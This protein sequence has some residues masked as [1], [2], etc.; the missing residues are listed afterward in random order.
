MK[1]RPRTPLQTLLCKTPNYTFLK[2]FGCACFPMLRTHNSNKLQYWSIVYI[3]GLLLMSQ[4]IKSLT[5]MLTLS[6]V[7]VPICSTKKVSIKS[8]LPAQM[9]PG[10]IP[11]TC[12]LVFDVQSFL[13][14]SQ[15]FG[16]LATCIKS[17]T[18]SQSVRAPTPQP[19][20]TTSLSTIDPN[21]P[22]YCPTLSSPPLSTQPMQAQPKFGIVKPQLHPTYCSLQ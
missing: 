1:H 4:G 2:V 9:S 3:S 14:G 17:S 10:V 21:Y 19:S 16:F 6:W 11:T 13:R 7:Q 12:T 20:S 15:S 22:V 8:F 18:S 5:E